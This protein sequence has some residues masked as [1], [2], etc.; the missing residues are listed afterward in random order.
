[1]VS[2]RVA[3]ELILKS[4]PFAKFLAEARE[5]EQ[6]GEHDGA[7]ENYLVNRA[8]HRCDRQSLLDA[9]EAGKHCVFAVSI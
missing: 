1:M 4:D 7:L 6:S 8:F 3:G 5:A 9:A 2:G